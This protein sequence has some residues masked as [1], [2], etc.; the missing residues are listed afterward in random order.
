MRVGAL[1]HDI[2][3]TGA[4]AF[5]IENQ[6][7]KS[8]HD[9]LPYEKSAEV[10]VQHVLHGAELAK[11]YK[12]PQPI[13]DF[14]LTHHGTGMVKYFYNKYVNENDGKLPDITKF[15]YPGP[16]PFT[17]ETAVLMM[18]D[19]VEA[20]SRTLKEYNENTID[21]L[22]EKII[23]TQLEDGQF[24]EADITF[25]DIFKVKQVLKEKLHNI[26]HARIEYPEKKV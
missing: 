26:Y 21:E 3:K 23:N 12:L 8:P 7:G 10:I 9:K 17:K 15:T 20:S 22:V 19:A 24:E 1:Y 14:I 18:A 5:F 6:S 13:T 4:P 11:K 25:K 16:A 2:G